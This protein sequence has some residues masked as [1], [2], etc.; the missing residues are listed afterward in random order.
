MA[1]DLQDFTLSDL[2]RV[3]FLPDEEFK[4]FMV[5]QG[6]L[7]GS[8]DCPQCQQPMVLVER[9][10]GRDV[11]WQCNRRVHRPGGTPKKGFK[12]SFLHTSSIFYLYTL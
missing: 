2:F 4:Q 3:L 11:V 6:L 5:S 1:N 8:M 12:V 9:G 10:G 7:H